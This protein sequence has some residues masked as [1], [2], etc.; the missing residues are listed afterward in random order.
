[1]RKLLQIRIFGRVQGVSF[2]YFAKEQ[3]DKLNL[4]GFAKNEKDGSVLIEIEG[5]EGSLEKF[6]DWCK[7]GSPSA[8]V[9]EVKVKESV[10]KGYYEF[11]TY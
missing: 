6:I 7:D 11:N 5:E 4:V 1:M 3:A 10:L 9:K 2:R 8:Q